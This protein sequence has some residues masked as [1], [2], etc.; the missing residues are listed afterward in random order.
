MIS[1]HSQPS[2]GPTP[3]R[4]HRHYGFNQ[5][6]GCSSH[7]SH[8]TLCTD[9]A[10]SDPIIERVPQAVRRRL[11]QLVDKL[12]LNK[13][14]LKPYSIKRGG[15]QAFSE[16]QTHWTLLWS[17]AAGTNKLHG[18]TEH[19]IAGHGNP[20]HH[21]RSRKQNEPSL[22]PFASKRG[23]SSKVPSLALLFSFQ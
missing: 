8:F 12:S 6:D 4:T 9:K 5:R 7:S 23:P 19:A 21:F 20:Q 18:F 3:E 16:P 13:L 15:A 22:W 14:L 17:K 1:R 11:R 2:I 10:A